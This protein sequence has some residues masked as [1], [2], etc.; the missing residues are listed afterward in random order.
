[1]KGDQLARIRTLAN[2]QNSDHEKNGSEKGHINPVVSP[3]SVIR[4]HGSF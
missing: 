1:M 2:E 3:L 4:D